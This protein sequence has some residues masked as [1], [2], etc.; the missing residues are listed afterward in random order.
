MTKI[1]R[2]SYVDAHANRSLN[3]D[4]LRKDER[5][6]EQLAAAGS[7]VEKVAKADLNGDGKISGRAELEALFRHADY[8]DRDGS[9]R[10]LIDLDAAGK[11]TAA[12][13]VLAAV[14]A[15]FA[16]TTRRPTGEDVAEA[17]LERIER[18]GQNYGVEGAWKSCNPGIPGNSRP[19]DRSLG[20]KGRWRC[21]LFAMDVLYQAGFQPATYSGDGKGWYPVAVDLPKYSKGA[22]RIFDNLGEVKLERLDYDAKKAALE[23]ILR[24]AQPGDLIIVNHVG[25]DAADGGHC[26]VVTE[27][28]FETDGTVDCAQASFDAAMV[29]QEGVSSFMGEEIVYLLRPCKVRAAS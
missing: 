5:A 4:K 21:N 16:S 24:R 15:S 12:G 2:Q 27:N 13:A 8:F 22:N 11:R 18:F 1:H 10:S 9:A 17:A 25:P 29:K 26:R 19:D 7:S 23:D 3:L 20:V 6:K 14:E 28:N